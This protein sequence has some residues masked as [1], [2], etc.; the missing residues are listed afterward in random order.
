MKQYIT[1]EC[2]AGNSCV[3]WDGDGCKLNEIRLD[4]AGGCI[5]FELTEEAWKDLVNVVTGGIKDE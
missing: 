1:V 4:E 5:R 3:N 2:S